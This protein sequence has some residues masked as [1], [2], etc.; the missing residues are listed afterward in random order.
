MFLFNVFV[1]LFV[2]LFTLRFPLLFCLSIFFSSNLCRFFRLI[3]CHFSSF[4]FLSFVLSSPLA[5]SC[6]SV[7]LLSKS[8]HS[9]IKSHFS[10]HLS[11]LVFQSLQSDLES[12][13]IPVTSLCL[14]FNLFIS[15]PSHFIFR[16]FFVFWL[17]SQFLGHSTLSNIQSV[18]LPVTSLCFLTS[19]FLS[20]LTQSGLQ[21]TT[22]SSQYLS[23]FKSQISQL[24]CKV[25]SLYSPTSQ[26]LSHFR[27][28]TN[29]LIC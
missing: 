19:Q 17:V 14:I 13:R 22:L 5:F 28:Q 6:P 25:T 16:F 2:C 9:D 10:N 20:H 23:H 3:L 1:F 29:Q 7:I 11:Q 8:L 27:S 24:I 26:Y 18:S 12:V 15:S 21:V 4:F